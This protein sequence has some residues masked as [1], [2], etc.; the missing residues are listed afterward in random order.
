M[1][2]QKCLHKLFEYKDGELI[3]GGKIAGSVNKKGYRCIGVGCK[4]YKA[5]RLVF[6]YH[7][8]YLPEQVD[9][10]DGNKLN[11]N[12]TNLR[13]A[14]NSVNMMNRGLM[15][16]NTS[17][18]K[19]VFWDKESCKWRVA[20]RV[21]TKLRSFGR[22]IDKELADLIAMMAREKYHKEFANHGNY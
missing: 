10:I 9:H 7:Y 21:G 20:I 16:N 15:R 18:Y 1:L 13:A 22:Y 12:V 6:M 8:G 5:H 17:G 2:T 4:I 3:R 11:N 19:G 14:D